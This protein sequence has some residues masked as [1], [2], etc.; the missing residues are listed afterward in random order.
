MKK[1]AFLLLALTM[2]VSVKAAS[3]QLSALFSYS[4]F[5]I[6]ESNKPYVE[7][8][9]SFDAWTLAFVEEEPGQLRATVEVTLVARRG[10]SIAYA[11]RY[12]LQLCPRASL[13]LQLATHVLCNP[14]HR[15]QHVVSQR[16][17]Y[18]ALYQRF[19]S[20]QRLRPPPLF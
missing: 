15:Q 5:Y 1:I 7:T 12:D 11:K 17:R 20:G 14:H 13:P 10:D 9:L 4:L 8:Y 2:T 19:C 6:P 18:G 16:L 3:P